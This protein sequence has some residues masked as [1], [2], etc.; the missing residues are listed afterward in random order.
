MNDTGLEVR[1]WWR[2]LA[3]RS[4]AAVINAVLGY[5]G[6]L[7]LL[8]L[9]DLLSNTVG[10]GLGW[11][12]PDTKFGSDGVLFS[13]AFD[14][15]VLV[16]FVLLFFTVNLWTARLL[17]V[18]GPASWVSAVLITV[19]PTVVATVAPDLWTAVRWY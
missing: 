7:P 18:S 1:A 16:F 5:V 8:L 13:V 2:R 10:V 11:A 14:V 4:C 17:K 15:V 12:E 6:V 3:G 19:A 9:V